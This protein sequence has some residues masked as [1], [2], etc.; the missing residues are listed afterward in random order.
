[1]AEHGF[2]AKEMNSGWAEWTAEA[3][4]NHENKDQARGV[5]RCECSM[6]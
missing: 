2:F 5:L 3:L 4:P 1:L 6:K